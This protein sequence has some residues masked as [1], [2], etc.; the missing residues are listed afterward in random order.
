MDYSSERHHEE[1]NHSAKFHG[2]VSLSLVFGDGK[3]GAGGSVI[4]ENIRTASV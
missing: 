2:I 1:A 4:H 3:L